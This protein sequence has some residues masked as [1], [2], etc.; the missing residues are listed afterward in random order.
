MPT[1]WDDTDYAKMKNDLLQIGAAIMEGGWASGRGTGDPEHKGPTADGICA[2]IRSLR[3]AREELWNEL[4]NQDEEHGVLLRL[5]NGVALPADWPDFI[6]EWPIIKEWHETRE[7]PVCSPR[8]E[9]IVMYG[10]ELVGTLTVGG[11][12]FLE[13]LSLFGRLSSNPLNVRVR[14][15]VEAQTAAEVSSRTDKT[16]EFQR[17]YLD[18]LEM[19]APA[20]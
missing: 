20:K 2:E 7:R 19:F 12:K 4:W 11:S 15:V 3:R 13:A 17:L 14:Y 8:Y 6:K 16:E 1:H 18:A 5:V 10:D 9:I